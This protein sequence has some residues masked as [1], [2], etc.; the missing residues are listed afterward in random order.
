MGFRKEVLATEEN[1]IDGIFKVG[2]LVVKLDAPKV[3]GKPVVRKVVATQ[4]STVLLEGVS[5]YVLFRQ[6]RHATEEEISFHSLASGT[7]RKPIAA[8]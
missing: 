8:Q 2:Y 1:K 5:C 3:K 6:I 7:N 4:R